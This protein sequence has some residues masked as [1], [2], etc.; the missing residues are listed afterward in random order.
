[1]LAECIIK[2]RGVVCMISYPEKLL[3]D[4][5]VIIGSIALAVIIWGVFFCLAKW[6]YGEIFNRTATDSA[7][8]RED[9]R[10]SLGSYILL[11]L[12]ILIV[13]DII[14]TVIDPTME[15]IT[16][17]GAIVVIRTIISVFLDKEIKGKDKI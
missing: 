15:E 8:R 1:M 11:G 7:S 16:I 13:A 17:L 6:L 9:A 2:D 5:S 14:G 3:G 10:R 4:L 12:E